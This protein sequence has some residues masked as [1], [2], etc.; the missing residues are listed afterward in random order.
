MLLAIDTVLV[1]SYSSEDVGPVDC[2]VDLVIE[3]IKSRTST[4]DSST[5]RLRG[6][7]LAQLEL[8]RLLKDRHDN[9]WNT[10]FGMCFLMLGALWSGALMRWLVQ[11]QHPSPPIDVSS[12]FSAYSEDRNAFPRT[13]GHNAH[14][15]IL[16]KKWKNHQKLK[17]N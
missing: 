15:E 6:P 17:K 3:F 12:I 13:V 4:D 5:R 14:S 9:R 8:M 2:T 16:L 10:V 7:Y 1:L 11:F